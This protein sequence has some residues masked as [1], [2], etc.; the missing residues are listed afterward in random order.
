MAPFWSFAHSLGY[1]LVA[2]ICEIAHFHAI[3]TGLNFSQISKFETKQQLVDK[4]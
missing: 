1:G 2:G 4:A 3:Y